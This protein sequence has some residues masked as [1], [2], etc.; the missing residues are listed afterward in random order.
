M[1]TKAAVTKRH[2]GFQA[3]GLILGAFISYISWAW[4]VSYSPRLEFNL[5][6]H[7]LFLFWR[8]VPREPYA[9]RVSKERWRILN[10][11]YW[12]YGPTEFLVWCRVLSAGEVILMVPYL[13]CQRSILSA[14]FWVTVL[15]DV[16][17]WCFWRFVV[18]LTPRSD[19]GSYFGWASTAA[20]SWMTVSYL[21][22]Q[23][24]LSIHLLIVYYFLGKFSVS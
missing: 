2:F 24:E 12:L 11:R 18:C 10:P 5:F 15:E 16:W 1:Q 8:Y 13:I 23:F 21:V 17:L 14:V 19:T 7:L 22:A 9:S 6:H 3:Q 4:V 20:V